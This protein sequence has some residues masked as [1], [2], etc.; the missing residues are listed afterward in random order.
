MWL[1]KG[2]HCHNTCIDSVLQYQ[3]EWTRNTLGTNW[4]VTSKII[5][6]DSL[7]YLN[8]GPIFFL[9]SLLS[10]FDLRIGFWGY[11]GNRWKDGCNLGLC[12]ISC[13]FQK[14]FTYSLSNN[15]WRILTNQ[16]TPWWASNCRE[17]SVRD[18]K[19]KNISVRQCWQIAL[20][21]A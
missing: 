14:C 5:L 3:P 8:V 12:P 18:C 7:Q 13:S 2:T 15:Q 19:Y 6:W 10:V 9:C 11:H 1:V 16:Q 4:G 17:S 21:K 20:L